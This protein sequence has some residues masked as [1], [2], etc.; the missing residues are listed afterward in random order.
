MILIGKCR[1]AA[2]PPNPCEFAMSAIVKPIVPSRNL[3]GAAG[4][5]IAG[6]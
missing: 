4:R 1:Y 2:H 6:A 5:A 3:A